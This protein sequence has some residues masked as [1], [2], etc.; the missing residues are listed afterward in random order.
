[1]EVGIGG[2]TPPILDET[3]PS[4]DNGGA[5]KG[6]SDD[7]SPYE[8]GSLDPLSDD[9]QE[10]EARIM[11]KIQMSFYGE[12]RPMEATAAENGREKEPPKA[13]G[14]EAVEGSVNLP[15]SSSFQ[16]FLSQLSKEKLDELASV[17]SS[18]SGQPGSASTAATGGAAATQ[19]P[20]KTATPPTGGESRGN[21]E[22][23]NTATA[24]PS[25][26]EAGGGGGGQLNVGHYDAAAGQ[27]MA[28]HQVPLQ[29]LSNNVGSF[30]TERQWHQE[31][32]HPQQLPQQAQAQLLYQGAQQYS[33][34]QRHPTATGVGIGNGA[35]E[36]PQAYPVQ[37]GHPYA[38]YP[39]PGQNQAAVTELHQHQESRASGIAAV[40]NYA[41]S[42]SHQAYGGDRQAHAVAH[43][44]H[45]SHPHHWENREDYRQRQ[46]YGHA[47]S[48]YYN[49]HVGRG[50]PYTRAPL[51]RGHLEG[52][53]RGGWER[54]GHRGHHYRGRG[55]HNRY[56]DNWH[57]GE[58]DRDHHWR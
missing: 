9:V 36:H 50:G 37:G 19:S 31:Q 20:I 52:K 5:E 55:G 39:P 28:S 13:G 26:T 47:S 24:I 2:Q 12:H 35:A 6:K 56:H 30:N 29:Q 44:A 8:P 23:V 40:T 51:H 53:P 11:R 16:S 57:R 48:H 22:M 58:H 42:Q 33:A 14:G 17:V 7:D 21:F 38:N 49:E 27:D 43:H 1:M 32:P 25:T 10:G 4:S 41:A 46:D 3:P 34:E 45:Q 15:T 54:G 18:I